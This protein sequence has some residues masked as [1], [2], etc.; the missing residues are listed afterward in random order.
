MISILPCEATYVILFLFLFSVHFHI[1]LSLPVL[2]D[3]VQMVKLFTHLG[4]LSPAIF[5]LIYKKVSE[6]KLYYIYILKVHLDYIHTTVQ[7]LLYFICSCWG[8]GVN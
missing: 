6:N 3:G 4:F 8:G 7:L 5:L 1:H 2:Q